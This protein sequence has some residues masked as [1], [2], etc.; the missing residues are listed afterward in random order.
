MR[1]GAARPPGRRPGPGRPAGSP[2]PRPSLSTCSESWRVKNSSVKLHW[3]SYNENSVWKFLDVS[4]Q[5]SAHD[6]RLGGPTAFRGKPSPDGGGDLPNAS[7]REVA[8]DEGGSCSSSNARALLA[9]RRALSASGSIRLARGLFRPRSQTAGARG[10]VGR[11]RLHP[12]PSRGAAGI[13]SDR[14]P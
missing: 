8:P 10:S 9:G 5:L 12:G 1:L 6:L 2:G 7:G 3:Q 4:I 14:A 13:R 11:L